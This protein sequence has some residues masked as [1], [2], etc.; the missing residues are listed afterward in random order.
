MVLARDIMNSYNVTLVTAG[1]VLSSDII[2]FLAKHD[3][4]TIWIKDEK[5]A[6]REIAVIP[7]LISAATR[8]NMIKAVNTAFNTR[9]G[10]KRNLALLKE[11]IRE[12]VAELSRHETLLIY[13]TDIR[14][15]REYLYGHCVDVGVFAMSIG[16]AMGLA[17]EDI[18]VLGLGGLLHDYG[19][20]GISE[21]ILEKKGPLTLG[22]FDL[23]KQHASL[24]Y[25]ALRQEP[26]I[27]SRIALIALQHHE[28]IDGRGYPW[29]VGDE[30][31]H[32]LARVVAVADV[33][34]ALITDRAYRPRFSYQRAIQII[35]AAG[36]SQFDAKVV[37]AFERIAVPYSIGSTVKLD[38]GMDGAILRINSAEPSRP[39][40]WTH[41]GV[42]N[43]HKERQLS[44]IAG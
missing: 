35:A 41:A 14:Q 42:I 11:R 21:D 25:N 39:V 40:V 22:E 34:D 12:V 28:R 7:N 5:A 44:I 30:D 38:N 18:L 19:K 3:V 29:G 37:A 17:E 15:R 10:I 6:N 24:G 32:P 43:L 23:V 16:M 27:D 26:S 36:G 8:L 2:E 33:Y 1:T 31:I 9:G 4:A 13:L 20:T